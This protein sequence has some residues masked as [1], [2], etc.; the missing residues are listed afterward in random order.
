MKFIE[1]GFTNFQ[2]FD[3]DAENI[4]IADSIAKEDP[5]IKMRTKLIKQKWIPKFDAFD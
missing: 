3:D 2:F 4:R 5:N 1:M